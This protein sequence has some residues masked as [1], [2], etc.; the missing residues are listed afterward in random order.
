M[1]F[2]VIATRDFDHMSEVAAGLAI[3]DIR[4]KLASKPSY[5]LGPATGN[6][7][8]GL[9]ASRQG[10]QRRDNRRIQN[11]GLQFQSTTRIF[12]KEHSKASFAKQA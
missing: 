3:E 6:S 4:L 2:H 1:A 9:Q 5:V 12:L 11:S 10:S 8:T 7:P